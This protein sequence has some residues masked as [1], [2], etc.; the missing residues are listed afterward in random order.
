MLKLILAAFAALVIVG[1]LALPANG[2]DP[3]PVGTDIGTFEA[4]CFY[5][6]RLADDPIVFPRG[7]GA[8]HKHDF[9]GARTT[10]AFSTHESIRASATSC[11]RYDTPASDVDHSAYWAPTLYVNGKPVVATTLGAYYNAGVRHINAIEP[12][13]AN[14]RM[15]AGSSAGGPMEIDGERVWYYL[16]PGGDLI[17]GTAVTAPTCKTKVLD[18]VMR[19]PD[20]WD[21]V[22]L[23][24]PD[25][26]SH[27]AYS[28][29]E[30]SA[31]LRTCPP[32]HPRLVPKLSLILRYPTKAGPTLGLA[33]GQINSAH[34]DFMNG[35]DQSKLEALV[36]DCLVA[37]RYCGGGDV[38]VAGH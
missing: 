29:R 13:P 10:D 14:L 30:T 1:A 2:S 3:G 18:L 35:W 33:S 32:T 31:A 28:R 9:F 25:H 4:V 6:H 11:V 8:S 5:S 34:A 7:P 16:C 37:D 20:C 22:N 24:S 38:P 36:R 19:F 12:F 21:G 26:K 15:I 27:M 23:D 17:P